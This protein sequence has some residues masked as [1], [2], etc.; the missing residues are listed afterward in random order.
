MKKL[1]SFIL[2]IPI[3]GIWT[4]VIVP[5]EIL[6]IIIYGIIYLIQKKI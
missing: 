4:F 2:M 3:L 6:V 1:T 5:F